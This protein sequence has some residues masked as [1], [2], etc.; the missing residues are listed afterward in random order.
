MRLR[1]NILG[2]PLPLQDRLVSNPPRL[3]RRDRS[4]ILQSLF[5]RGVRLRLARG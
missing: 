5:R 3:R 2:A 1:K 4:V